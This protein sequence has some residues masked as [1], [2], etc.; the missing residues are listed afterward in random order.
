MLKPA[1]FTDLR[2]YIKRRVTAA[3]YYIGSSGYS[4]K[5]T[6]VAILANGTIRAQLAILPNA[7][8]TVTVK[9]VEL[10][11]SA[12]ELWAEKSC[13]IS[14]TTNQTGVLFW[15]DIAVTEQEV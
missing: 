4:T 3:K 15:F 11:N 9:K 8:S 13:S 5:L 7:S 14:I 6:D 10:Y 1:A 12:G 2:S